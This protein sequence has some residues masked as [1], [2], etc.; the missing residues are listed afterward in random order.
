MSI[1]A[2]L[3]QTLRDLLLKRQP[4]E[5]LE[6]IYLSKLKLVYMQMTPFS[7]HIKKMIELSMTNGDAP[8]LLSQAT[9]KMLIRLITNFIPI[10]LF[11]N[12]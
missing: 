10:P 7:Q 8:T 1:T 2:N 6:M 9:V 12:S 11:S 5:Q 4:E 3:K